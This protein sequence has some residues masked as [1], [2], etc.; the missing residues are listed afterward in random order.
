MSM[1]FAVACFGQRTKGRSKQKSEYAI[2]VSGGYFLNGKM[3]DFSNE[4][5]SGCRMLQF[6]IQKFKAYNKAGI[7]FT[8]LNNKIETFRSF[9]SLLETRYSVFLNYNRMFGLSKNI[10]GNGF[11]MGGYIGAV[12]DYA[13]HDPLTNLTTDYNFRYMGIS[14]GP[15]AEYFHLITSNIFILA[16]TQFGL[17]ELGR[18]RMVG[19]DPQLPIRAQRTNTTYTSLANRLNL[20]LGISYKF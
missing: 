1:L 9:Y 17:I 3:S 10:N 14:F 15:K 19:D 7:T 5:Y 2:A 18:K 11:F 4:S 16:G 13:E 20:N 8:F 6:D 12:Y